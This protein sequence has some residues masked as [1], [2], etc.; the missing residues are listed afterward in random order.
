MKKINNLFVTTAVIT[1]TFIAYKLIK[2]NIYNNKIKK[3][4]DEYENDSD[5]ISFEDYD[6]NDR[7]YIIIR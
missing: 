4:D 1:T 7:Q 2:K 6:N 5:I 3:Q